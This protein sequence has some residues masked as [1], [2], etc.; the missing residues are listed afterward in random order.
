MAQPGYV[1]YSG[2]LLSAYAISVDKIKRKD[3]LR[4]RREMEDNIKMDISEAEY[5]M[6]RLNCL[7]MGFIGVIYG[8]NDETSVSKKL[9]ILDHLH[10]YQVLKYTW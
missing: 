4:R 10:N 5:E 6:T 7:R 2:E 8:H 1:E 3:D 9:K